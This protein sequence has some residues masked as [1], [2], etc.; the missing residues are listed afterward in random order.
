MRTPFV[1]VVAAVIGC[2][3]AEPTRA[4]QDADGG[5]PNDGGTTQDAGP[6]DGGA[7]WAQTDRAQIE[8]LQ[9]DVV[10]AGGIRLRRQFY[11]NRG[12]RCGRTG[13][14]TFVLFEREEA[15]GASAPLWVYLHGGGVGYYD[16]LHVYHGGESHNDEE[17][18]DTLTSYVA[19]AYTGAMVAKP[20]VVPRRLAEGYR[21]LVPSMCDH[22]L[23]AGLGNPYPNNPHWAQEGGDHVDG[24]LATLSAI[25]FT[26]KGNGLTGVQALAPHPT[27]LVF[28]HGG[29]AGSAGSYHVSAVMA[30]MGMPPNGAILDSYLVNPLEEILL[31]HGC[32]PTNDDPQF[33]LAEVNAKIGVLI[34][35]PDLRVD[36]NFTGP[37][38]VPM[39]DVV[40][41]NDPFC[42]GNIAPVAEATA[43]GQT[44]NCAWVHASFAQAAAASGDGRLVSMVVA[45]QGHVITHDEG[46]H[47]AA[48]ETWLRGIL[49]RKPI[50]PAFP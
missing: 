32:T 4:T 41:A 9:E 5:T 24:L 12:Y 22:D 2:S 33:S 28:L 40:G 30:R 15:A 13:H 21:L 39:F 27:T 34:T 31:G 47:Q 16:A 7:L 6:S 23:Y 25:H 44:N 50:P 11:R 36:A 1:F 35:R 3:A 49:D 17:D 43:A 19:R 14:F 20:V 18:R 45:G 26:A 10:T 46:P 29:S 38:A 42:C 37:Y 48:I 8:L